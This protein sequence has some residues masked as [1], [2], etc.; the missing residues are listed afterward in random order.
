MGTDEEDSKE[1]D[2]RGGEARHSPSARE[3]VMS[4]YA[5][6]ETDYN[7]GTGGYAA[8]PPPPHVPLPKR[9]GRLGSSGRPITLVANHFF[10]D[11]RRMV[12]LSLY[13]VTITPPMP[14]ERS[15]GPRGPARQQERVLPARLCRCAPTP[16]PLRTPK[17][18]RVALDTSD[19]PMKRRLSFRE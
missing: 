18:G 9:A 11:V 13:D 6:M 14:K 15:G 1:S 16:T 2:V 3:A 7:G 4:S 17:E 12:E 8:P 19:P 10:V 5:P